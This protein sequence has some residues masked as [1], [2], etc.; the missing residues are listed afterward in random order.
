[1]TRRPR[2]SFVVAVVALLGALILLPGGRA[3]A[4]VEPGDDSIVVTVFHGDGCPHCARMLAF[5]DELDDRYPSIEVRAYE[6]WHDAA[7]QQRFVA[8][9]AEFGLEPRSVPTVIVGEL[10]FVGYTD[11]IADRIT[12][13]VA[14]LVADRAPTNAGEFVIDVPFV[15]AVDVESR[16]MVGATVLIAF[17]DGV[18][19][20]SLWVL[21]MLLALVVHSGSRS[22]VALVGALFLVVTS[23][24]YGLY[25]LGA[26]STLA[27]VGQETWIR[28]AVALVAGAFGVLHLK[29][30]WTTRG[31][32]VTIASSRKPGILRR[33][34]RLADPERSLGATLAGTGVLAVGVSLLETPCSAGLPLLWTNLLNDRGVAFGGAAFLFVVYLLVF[35]L[36]E[37]LVFGAVVVTMRA[38]K[39]QEEH[40]RL[41]Q[42]VGG[43]LMVTLAVVMLAAPRLLESVTGTLLAFAIATTAVAA[44]LVVE[45]SRRRRQRRHR[46]QRR[47]RPQPAH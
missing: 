11:A 19:P 40:G 47:R 5:L 46:H 25:M 13:V 21:S 23:A 41:L 28:A 34:R 14:D 8:D 9:M 35:L 15:G 39:L 17:V 22:R 30:H 31:P 2:R 10:V 24:L 38:A 33:M 45:R 44:V 29:E 4:T 1:V 18:N 7:N 12:A 26:Y 42:L 16:S 27:V 36:D 43:A 37:L 3:T 32:S 6:V 20:C